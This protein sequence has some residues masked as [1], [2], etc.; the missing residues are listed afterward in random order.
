MSS[1][2]RSDAAAPGPLPDDLRRIEAGLRTLRAEAP[3]GLRERV[4]AGVRS[5]LERGSPRWWLGFAA[6]AGLL[7][8]LLAH[9]APQG[10][11]DVRR[12]MAGAWRHASLSA[13]PAATL[14]E[15]RETFPG[16]TPR[17]ASDLARVLSSGPQ[18]VS[19]ASRRASMSGAA[20]MASTGIEG[21]GVSGRGF[22]ERGERR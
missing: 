14:L 11:D 6:A 7:A 2:D 13:P 15:I 20:G 10:A 22:D 19:A 16:L 8:W 5:E 3:P 1:K 21:R 17:E 18:L 9:A 4:V 12:R